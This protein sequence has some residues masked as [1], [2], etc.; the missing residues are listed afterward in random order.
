MKEVFTPVIDLRRKVFAEIAR[1]AYEG[2][3]YSRV[4]NLPYKIIPGEIATYRE[5]I[6]LERAIVAERLRLAMSLPLRTLKEHAPLSEGVNESAIGK[7]YFD[8]PLVN[9]IRFACHACA[10]NEVRVTD[11]CQGCLAHPCKEVCPKGAISIVERKSVID[12]EKCIQCGLCTKVCPYHAIIQQKR[13]CAQA[14]GM[15]AIHSDE[16]GRAEIDQD[17]CVSCG[18]CISHCP[19]GA[20]SDKAQIFQLIQAMKEGDEVVAV[21]APAFVNQFGPKV[22]A[23]KLKE[24]LKRLGFSDTAWVAMGADLC[25]I[26]E[27]EDFLK[28]VPAEQ[29][30][31]ATSCC[32]S[33]SMMAKMEF[34]EH[35]DKVSMAMT[36]MVFTARWVKKQKPDCKVVF[37]GPCAAKKLEASRQSVKS[38]VDFVLTFEEIMGMFE[39][40]GLGPAELAKLPD[41][42]DEDK[43]AT[44][45]G[46]GF[47]ISGG[48][49]GAV[50]EAIKR[51]APEREVLIECADGL[52]NCRKML[53]LAAAGKKDG[54][55][56]EGMACPGGCVAGT[57]TLAK[58]DR[59]AVNVKKKMAAAAKQNAMDSPIS[60][61][62]HSLFETWFDEWEG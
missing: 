11:G 36:P 29:S 62:L 19:F 27:A 45:A 12:Q 5:S 50:A 42:L 14:C 38:H 60:D 33:W 6:F 32:P 47:P 53:K 7:K 23:G 54:Y 28:K 13:P 26:D 3:D 10:E 59:A 56:L 48:V 4:E 9:I 43:D 35:A 51:I 44:A 16:L 52:D 37:I 61:E 58:P 18:M 39:A 55:L 40:K 46:I 57:G 31:M 34:P 25:T 21:V 8:P 20:I 49:A 15:N 24:G 30:F 1:L 17:R 22:T 41:N 2:G